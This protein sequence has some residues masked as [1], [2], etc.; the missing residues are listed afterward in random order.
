MAIRE[1]HFNWAK[2]ELE[3]LE[4]YLW[5]ML[6]VDPKQRAASEGLLA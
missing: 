6:I 1:I 2:G 5:K 4:R 3:L